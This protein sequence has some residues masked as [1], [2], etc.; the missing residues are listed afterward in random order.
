MTDAPIVFV[1]DRYETT[2]GDWTIVGR[3]YRPGHYEVTATGPC[4]AS[5]RNGHEFVID[6]DRDLTFEVHS[7]EESRGWYDASPAPRTAPLDVI[8]A[9]IR[10]WYAAKAAFSVQPE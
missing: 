6:S 3:S 7:L 8:E 5:G 4:T 2:V 1:D 10:V 9:A